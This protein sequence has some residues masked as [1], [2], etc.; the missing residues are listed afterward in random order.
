MEPEH[1]QTQLTQAAAVNTSAF[2]HFLYNVS[3]I[4]HESSDSVI[5]ST[6]D[7]KWNI[8]DCSF[9]IKYSERRDD[10]YRHR[11]HRMEPHHIYKHMWVII[12]DEGTLC[13][14]LN[15]YDEKD[16]GWVYLIDD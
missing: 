13:E 16:L 4:W 2:L 5:E 6:I 14:E 1:E 10:G 7:I 8:H 12:V 9:H 15:V 3:E 11:S